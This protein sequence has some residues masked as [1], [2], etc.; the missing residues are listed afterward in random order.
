MGRQPAHSASERRANSPSMSVPTNSEDSSELKPRWPMDA[1]ALMMSVMELTAVTNLFAPALALL[2][3]VS[4]AVRASVEKRK[5]RAQELKRGFWLLVVG[6]VVV[7]MLN[8][9]PV[10]EE[11]VAITILLESTD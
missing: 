10:D 11:W 9:S 7:G 6:E 2:S 3:S 8:D 1:V 5:R 4:W